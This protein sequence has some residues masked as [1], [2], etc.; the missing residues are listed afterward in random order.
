LKRAVRSD[1]HLISGLQL[2]YTG[3]SWSGKL[4]T[5]RAFTEGMTVSTSS[6]P[7]AYNVPNAARASI[8]EMK[9]SHK[10]SVQTYGT[11]PIVASISTFRPKLWQIEN[12][13]Y[14]FS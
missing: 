14:L 11:V 3:L 8:F 4:E 2:W 13:R 9:V 5:A 10:D 12:R 1:C 7:S 6:V